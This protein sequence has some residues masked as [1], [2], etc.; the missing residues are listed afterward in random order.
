MALSDFLS[1][2]PE[3]GAW[4]FVKQ[5]NSQQEMQN[6]QK[7]QTLM[8]LLQAAQAQKM[9]EQELADMEQ[10]K[11]T[12][13]QFGGD[14]EKTIKALLSTGNPRAIEMASKLKGL[15][16]K[17]EDS[18]FSKPDIKDY[19]PESI[20]KFMRTKNP[21]DLVPVPPKPD[22]PEASPEIV[23]L[24]RLIE[25]TPPGPMRDALQ[26]RVDVMNKD[27]STVIN[28][29]NPAPVTALT[30]RDP[31]SPTGWSYVDGRT[32]QILTRGAPPPTQSPEAV[33]FAGGRAGA[34]E[35]GKL[36]AGRDFNMQGLSGDLQQAEDL[37]Q[38]IRRDPATGAPMSAPLPTG[39]G[40]GKVVDRLGAVVGYAPSGAA[41]AADLKVVAGRLT[42]KVPRFE[43]PQ[44]DRDTQLY[45]EMA[46]QAGDEG[47]PRSTRLSA[48]RK[49][50]E[51]YSKY[52]KTGEVKD[53]STG[54]VKF[55]GFENK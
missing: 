45:K 21:A 52:E 11:G 49:M 6:L 13:S 35:R 38:G 23:K 53:A 36:G 9:K 17:P 44:S 24:L 14:P 26:R 34:Q 27:P 33:Q 41:E 8:G 3:V 32:K 4:E 20:A 55:L 5:R 47:L 28:N 12:V 15:M 19:T 31:S 7:T 50:R 2:N 48:V 16:P 10:I 43:G 1:R 51:L 46:A 54:K 29:H 39:S 25:S 22:K 30:V 40:V 18:A 37:L 42:Q